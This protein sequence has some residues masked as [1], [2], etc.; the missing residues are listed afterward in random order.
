MFNVSKVTYYWF[1]YLT[2]VFVLCLWFLIFCRGNSSLS[3]WDPLFIGHDSGFLSC[4]DGAF[5]S[6]FL[7]VAGKK[8]TTSLCASLLLHIW[9]LSEKCNQSALFLSN[10]VE[11]I[12]L[13]EWL[14]SGRFWCFFVK[15]AIELTFFF[16]S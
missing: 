13:E 6:N 7:T 12:F 15:D 5:Y 2:A 3:L 9:D 4:P 1:C 14:F 11:E 16:P 10:M 8:Y